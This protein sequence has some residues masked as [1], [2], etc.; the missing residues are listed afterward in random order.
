M[1]LV[2]VTNGI[3]RDMEG[4]LSVLSTRAGMPASMDWGKGRSMMVTVVSEREAEMKD[5]LARVVKIV[6]VVLLLRRR[7]RRRAKS[8]S[9]IVWPLDMNGN[10]KTWRGIEVVESILLFLL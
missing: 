1:S 3:K 9:G 10:S 5:L 4:S 2:E 7:R 6:T 8:R